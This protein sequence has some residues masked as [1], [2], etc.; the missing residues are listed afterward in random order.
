MRPFVRSFTVAAVACAFAIVPIVHARAAGIDDRTHAERSLAA[1]RASMAEI[2]RVED[3]NDVGHDKYVVAAERARNLLVGSKDPAYVAAV[4]GETP[5][6]VGAIGHI[7]SL[8]DRKGTTVWT[9]A[10]QG[11]KMN[12]LAAVVSMTDALNEKQM[13]SYENDLSQALA[14]IA[15]AIGRTSDIGIFG[16]IEGALA[17]TTLGI[18]GGADVVSGC[19][20]PSRAPAYGVTAGR[21]TFV[22]LP[23]RNARDVPVPNHIVAKRV[24]FQADRV[25]FFTGDAS[26]L[27]TLCATSRTSAFARTHPP[28]VIAMAASPAPLGAGVAPA[29]PAAATPSAAAASSAPASMPSASTPD[30]TATSGG[31][32]AAPTSAPRASLSPAAAKPHGTSSGASS[33]SSSSG[34]AAAK[35]AAMKDAPK[36][37]AM[38]VGAVPAAAFTAAQAHAGAAVYAQSC[39]SCHGT[40]LQGS[41]GP[42]VAGTEFLKSVTGNG[43]TY[44]D[45]RNLVTQQMPLNN[46]GTLSPKAYAEVLAFLLAS[47]CFPAGNT[48]FPQTD[49]PKFAATKIAAPTGATPTDVK[50][51]TCAVK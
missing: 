36:T 30:P 4:G 37:G 23:R 40:N 39:A 24:S 51:G 2:V 27:A 32:S 12:L 18:P 10:L 49:S 3:G 8:L 20:A 45:F 35:G 46:A 16:G 33:K 9:P 25:I 14:D 44:A 38:A 28:R 41:A 5:D 31:A 11:A 19:A 42:A 21:L 7:D 6:G 17:S 29:S 22:A 47:S 1:I 13:E 48:A 50:L 15:L 34:G 43:W 26:K